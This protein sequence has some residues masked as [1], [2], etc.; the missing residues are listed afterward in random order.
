MFPFSGGIPDFFLFNKHIFCI[1]FFSQVHFSKE[2]KMIFK[3]NIYLSL[4]DVKLVNIWN[5]HQLLLKCSGMYQTNSNLCNFWKL[6]RRSS[7]NNSLPKFL[8]R[9]GVYLANLVYPRSSIRSRIR[10]C[11]ILVVL[12][13][14]YQI[15]LFPEI[16][17]GFREP[18]LDIRKTV[19]KLWKF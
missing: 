16:F 4:K 15:I 14:F 13:T 9:I 5:I 11:P 7:K 10:V 17:Q 1:A 12:K 6:H 3:G 8:K 2:N 18:F 19:L